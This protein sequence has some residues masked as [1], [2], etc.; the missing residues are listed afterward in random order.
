MVESVSAL[1]KPGLIA[2][3]SWRGPF[4]IPDTEA[5]QAPSA[6]AVSFAVR[7]PALTL[8]T[9]FGGAV[10]LTVTVPASENSLETSVIATATGADGL[11]DGDAV[12]PSAGAALADA[13]PSTAAA[14][15][16][17][18]AV[19]AMPARTPSSA[20]LGARAVV[21]DVV[22][23]TR[24]PVCCGRWLHCAGVGC[25]SVER[26]GAPPAR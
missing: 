24:Y 26:T 11:G 22:E 19:D 1:F 5:L 18:V 2:K 4:A 7:P 10:P 12:A 23:V 16:S 15:S 13:P 14:S 21:L 9:A 17:I 20:L 6:S 8:T 3:I 25:D